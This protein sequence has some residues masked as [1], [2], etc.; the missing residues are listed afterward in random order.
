LGVSDQGEFI[1]KTNFYWQFEGAGGAP[2]AVKNNQ[3]S[4]NQNKLK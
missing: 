2:K 4:V 1:F 3:S